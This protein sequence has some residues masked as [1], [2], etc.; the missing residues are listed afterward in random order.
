[1]DN[2]KNNNKYQYIV[3]YYGKD[4]IIFDRF[5]EWYREMRYFINQFNLENIV[6]I[7][8]RKLGYAVLDYF[9][10]IIRTKEFHKIENAN[11]SKIY[12]YT[13]YWICKDHPLQLISEIDDDNY[14]YINELFVVM[15]ICSRFSKR[16][17]AKEENMKS[18]EKLTEL[19]LYNFKFRVL[20]PYYV[21]MSIASFFAGYACGTGCE[22]NEA[23]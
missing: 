9:A 5:N 4:K 3:D 14:L 6:R 16:C 17:P 11:L 13:A 23:I 12:G 2:V 15:Q 21:E 1:M 8:D 7:D 19:L 20:S 10:D 22:C 18:F